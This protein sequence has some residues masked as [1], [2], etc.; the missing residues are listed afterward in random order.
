MI[1]KLADNRYIDSD[2]CGINSWG[3]LSQTSLIKKDDGWYV[4]T[5]YCINSVDD[6]WETDETKLQVIEE[7]MSLPEG[8][9]LYNQEE[10]DLLDMWGSNLIEFK[11]K[12][13]K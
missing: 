12:E 10:V 3:S 8:E 13:E 9:V 2:A 11:N 6:E 4:S 5:S 7:L 1:L